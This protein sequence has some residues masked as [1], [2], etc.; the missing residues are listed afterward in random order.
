MHKYTK[1]ITPEYDVLGLRESARLAAAIQEVFVDGSAR[2][3]YISDDVSLG[4]TPKKDPPNACDFAGK[5]K[6]RHKVR[7]A[8]ETPL[9]EYEAAARF[10]KLYEILRTGNVK[11]DKYPLKISKDELSRLAHKSRN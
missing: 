9:P 2:K 5:V 6:G 11:G 4:C 8:I 1:E 10:E 7:V 3:I